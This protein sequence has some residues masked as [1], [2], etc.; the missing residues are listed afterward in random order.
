[1]DCVAIDNELKPY[2]LL[3][4]LT[5]AC[6]LQCP[7]CSNPI[8][9]IEHKNELSTEEWCRV[10]REA[11]ELGATQIGFSG[12]EPLVRQDLEILI[13][14][15]RQL[16]F[17][18]NLITS[19][20]GMDTTRLKKIIHAG[21]DAIQISMQ[22]ANQTDN[23][24]LCGTTSFHHKIAMA[25]EAKQAG[26]PLTLNCVLHQKNIEDIKNILELC[27]TLQADYVELANAQ[28]YGFALQNRH[29]LLPTKAQVKK[30]EII[31]KEYRQRYQGRMKIY[32]IVSDYHE[33]RPK[34][35]VNGWGNIFLTITPNG[36]A[37]PCHMAQVIKNL[38]FPMVTE[39]SLQYIWKKSPLFNQ[40]RGY[41]WMKEPCQS[42]PERTKDFG[43]CR[44]QAYILTGDAR[45]ADPV[46]ELSPQHHRITSALNETNEQPLLFRN[47]RNAKYLV[48]CKRYD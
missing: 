36:T 30:A 39:H 25:R 26:L 3:L 38:K 46:C 42:C 31:A 2:W 24:Y 4:E 7:Y 43:G 6:P 8:D 11:R 34:A 10:L 1:M 16:G 47:S 19:T 33:K 45:N 28:Y 5:Y 21:L 27:V 44:C 35:C 20:Q 12:G 18:T 40:F 17:Y 41:H 23:D 9:Y 15:A 13:Q 14:K 29:H 37:L 22:A 48:G 32:Y